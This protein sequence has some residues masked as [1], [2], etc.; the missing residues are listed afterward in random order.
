MNGAT[1]IGLTGSALLFAAAVMWLTKARRYS[2]KARSLTFIVSFIAALLP[3]FELPIAG[4]IR[5]SVGDLSVTTLMLLTAT[6]FSR[7]RDN[8]PYSPQSFTALTFLVLGSGLILYTSALGLTYFDIYAL[9]YGTKLIMVVFLLLSLGAWFFEYPLAAICLSASALAYSLQIFE[10]RNLW[11][12]WIDPLLAVYALYWV[13][14]VAI[15]AATE[16]AER[17]AR[18]RA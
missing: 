4:Y 7:L 10:S 2:V 3:V 6:I 12:Y 9:G 15:G 11:D 8:R 17:D 5:G 18:L 14:R 1:W 13:S 16:K